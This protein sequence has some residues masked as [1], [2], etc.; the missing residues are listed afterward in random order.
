MKRGRRHQDSRRAMVTD[1]AIVRY[2]ERVIGVPDM[3]EQIVDDLL[4]DGREKNIPNIRACTKV[5]V[6][7][8]MELTIANGQVVTVVSTKKERNRG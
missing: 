6:D 8:R 3:I 5:R 2:I 4:S 1:H 7:G